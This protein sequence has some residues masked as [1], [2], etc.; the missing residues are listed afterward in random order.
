MSIV[1]LTPSRTVSITLPVTPS[2]D[3]CYTGVGVTQMV[4]NETPGATSMQLCFGAQASDAAHCT[5]LDN[6]Y[7]TIG[8]RGAAPHP[9]MDRS[10]FEEMAERLR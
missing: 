7:K 9:P 10:T 8:T 5:H 2:G 3:D 6:A 1:A 4:I